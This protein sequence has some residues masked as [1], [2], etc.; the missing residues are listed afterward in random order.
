MDISDAS[1][2]ELVNELRLRGYFHNQDLSLVSMPD[3]FREV[4]KRCT[5]YVVAMS[6]V[7]EFGSVATRIDGHPA[8]VAG[9]VKTLEIA[10]SQELIKG[11]KSIRPGT[12][13]ESEVGE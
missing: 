1:T 8:T 2:A 7:A 6:D 4:R 9:L 11:W 13:R 12:D 3:I 5:G 10:S